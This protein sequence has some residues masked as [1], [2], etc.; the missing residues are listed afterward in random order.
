MLD[1]VLVPVEMRRQIFGRNAPQMVI[2]LPVQVVEVKRCGKVSFFTQ[3]NSTVVNRGMAL[4][5]VLIPR[6]KMRCFGK[7]N[8]G[9]GVGK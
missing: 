7:R 8:H 3:S 5:W 9:G 1:A 4:F 2:N 6:G